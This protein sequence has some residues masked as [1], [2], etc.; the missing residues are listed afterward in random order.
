MA[1]RASDLVFGSALNLLNYFAELGG[2]TSLLLVLREGNERLPEKPEGSK[3]KGEKPVE[4]ELLPLELV[5]DL[6]GAFVNCGALM[7]DDFS[8]GFVDEVQAIIMRRLQGMQDREI[9]ELDKEALPAVL[10]SLK[11]FVSIVKGDDEISELHE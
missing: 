3:E 6:T 10:Q 7:A 8:V 4:K 9:K 5:G 2:F 1:S 11:A